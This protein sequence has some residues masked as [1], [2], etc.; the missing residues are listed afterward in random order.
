[1]GDCT[2]LPS[3]IQEMGFTDIGKKKGM[4]A[5]FYAV[6]Y[7]YFLGFSLIDLISTSS[8][9]LIKA[10]M[11]TQQ[12]INTDK[13]TRAHTTSRIMTR[14][15]RKRHFYILSGFYLSLWT[16]L[17][18]FAKHVQPCCWMAHRLLHSS[19]QWDEA[20]HI[21]SITQHIL[22]SLSLKWLLKSWPFSQVEKFHLWILF[23]G[24]QPL[25]FWRWTKDM[26]SG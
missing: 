3:V 12:N 26:L 22:S 6:F 7:W 15:T 23:Q 18:S 24:Q 2:S 1:M 16:A 20:F 14:P 9:W 17:F 11:K 8:P 5:Q 21:L 25:F 19:A 10:K 4:K 13:T